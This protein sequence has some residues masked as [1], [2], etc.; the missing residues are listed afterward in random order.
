MSEIRLIGILAR[1]GYLSCSKVGPSDRVTHLTETGAFH[2]LRH[3]AS[4][5]VYAANSAGFQ[6]VLR[7]LENDEDFVAH[8][9]QACF[10]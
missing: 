6:A 2:R 5:S 8:F 1:S 7:A 9:R 10:E 4:A 3:R